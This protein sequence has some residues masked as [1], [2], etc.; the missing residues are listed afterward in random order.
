VEL[1]KKTAIAAASVAVSAA[2]SGV[3]KIVET[4]DAAGKVTQVAQV[5]GIS[6]ALAGKLGDGMGQVVLDAGLAGVQA[7]ITSTASA[8]INSFQIDGSGLSFDGDRFKDGLTGALVSGAAVMAGSL[9]GN[10]TGGLINKTLGY[11]I[12]GTNFMEFA[13]TVGS[14]AGKYG[15]YIAKNWLTEGNTGLDALK[16]GF[17][18]AGGLTLNLA[19]LG[20]FSDKLKGMG[21]V[22]LNITS[23][24]V[25]SRFG[26]GGIDAWGTIAAGMYD[27]IKLGVKEIGR[28]VTRENVEKGAAMFGWG[29]EAATLFKGIDVIKGDA[30]IPSL[31]GDKDL[32][33]SISKNI[34]EYGD[35]VEFTNAIIAAAKNTKDAAESVSGYETLVEF[36]DAINAAKNNNSVWDMM[37]ASEIPEEFQSRIVE[38]LEQLGYNKVIIDMMKG[39][40]KISIVGANP[41]AGHEEFNFIAGLSPTEG[42]SVGAAYSSLYGKFYTGLENGPGAIVGVG[43]LGGAQIN[44]GVETTGMSVDNF[45][46]PFKTGKILGLTSAGYGNLMMSENMTTGFAFS[47]AATMPLGKKTMM[48]LDVDIGSNLFGSINNYNISGK[49]TR[50]LTADATLA[51][52]S[53]FQ[54]TGSTTPT[55][56]VGVNVGLETKNGS[57]GMGVKRY[58]NGSKIEAGLYFGWSK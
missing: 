10:L 36:A 16:G 9:T 19:G 15:V 52:G 32:A 6:K 41:Y 54:W 34:G 46:S 55:S 12:D 30:D 35:S 20:I 31:I 39:G 58:F 43:T 8:A 3:G 42:A 29:E 48:G 2:F 24:G 22:E 7:G 49:M 40:E 13:T 5:G 37:F 25:T 23:D 18:D 47:T 14:E 26:T 33:A 51:F 28:I 21:L 50:N 4:T 57:L 45:L 53:S 11:N 38:G 1:G 56:V 17:D 44:I 27:G